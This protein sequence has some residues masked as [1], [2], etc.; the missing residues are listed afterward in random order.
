MIKKDIVIDKI[1]QMKKELS[2]KE[3]ALAVLDTLK[4]F[5]ETISEKQPNKD[6][7]EAA[8][9]YVQESYG[10]NWM[11]FEYTQN[12]AFRAMSNFKFGAWWQ[13][14]HII[15]KAIKWVRENAYIYVDTQNDSEGNLC[16]V[17]LETDFINNFK[18]AMDEQ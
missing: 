12:A 14:E 2:C 1:E 6:L 7:E 4:E 3:D 17:F 5:V 13:K 16:E 15:E 9:N 8:Q 11:D 10:E 18:K